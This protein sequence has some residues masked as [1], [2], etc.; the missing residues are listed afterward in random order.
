MWWERIISYRGVLTGSGAASFPGLQEI[1]NRSPTEFKAQ[2]NI[3][4]RWD[5]QIN[6][7]ILQ[8]HYGNMAA[9]KIDFNRHI[10]HDDGTLI[11][12]K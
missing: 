6:L 8:F 9:N 5:L 7:K 3:N 12:S 1:I 4:Q 10:Q 2:H 11:I